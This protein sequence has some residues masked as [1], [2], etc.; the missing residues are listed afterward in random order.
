MICK[1]LISRLKIST[2]AYNED[3]YAKRNKEGIKYTFSNPNE[4]EKII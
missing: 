3:Y 2:S 4:D 1:E